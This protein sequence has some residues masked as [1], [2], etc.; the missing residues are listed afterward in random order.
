MVLN[1]KHTGDNECAHAERPMHPVERSPPCTV[2][3][4]A[5]ECDQRL[6]AGQAGGNAAEDG[7]QQFR[8]RLHIS[9]RHTR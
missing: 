2:V 9:G 6:K 3:G 7:V 4:G 1:T 8:V 5:G